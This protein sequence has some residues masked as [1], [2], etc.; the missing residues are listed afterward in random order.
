M[1]DLA[2]SRA[3]AVLDF[4][5]DGFPDLATASVEFPTFRLFHNRIGELATANFIAVRL[6][7]GNRSSEPTDSWSNRDAVGAKIR[8]E[9]EDGSVQV[10][11]RHLGEGLSAQNSSILLFG[12]GAREQVYS[13]SVDWPSGRQTELRDLDAGMLVTVFENPAENEDGSPSSSTT[14]AASPPVSVP[15]GYPAQPRMRSP[16]EMESDLTLYVSMATWCAACQ[17]KLPVIEQIREQF[18]PDNLSIVAIPVDETDTSEKLQAYQDQFQPSYQLMIDR[19]DEQVEW[20]QSV[21]RQVLGEETLPSSVLVDSSGRVLAVDWGLPSISAIRWKLEAPEPNHN[22]WRILELPQPDS[23]NHLD[24][25]LE[26]LI[27][28]NG[29]R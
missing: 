2:D 7:G 21:I 27:E 24:R 28:R 10:R 23:V 11:E 22:V 16:L 12:L 13:L 20:M 25:L 1:D 8:L 5:R 3:F 14:Y 9:H 6:V 18:S 4:D 15:P 19:T 26:E 17:S 29:R